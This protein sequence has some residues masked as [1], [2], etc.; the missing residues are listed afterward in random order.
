MCIVKNNLLSR[1]L[2]FYNKEIYILNIDLTTKLGFLD[3]KNL[4]NI[5]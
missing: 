5:N 1:E 2:Y 4:M 3:Q